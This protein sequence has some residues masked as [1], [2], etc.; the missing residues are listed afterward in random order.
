VLRLLESLGLAVIR[1]HETAI[2]LDG[3]DPEGVPCVSLL[4]VVRLGVY[5]AT[6]PRLLATG[7]MSELEHYSIAEWEYGTRINY[8]DRAL[9]GL[10]WSG[11]GSLPHS[12]LAV[13][14]S[15]MRKMLP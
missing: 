11:A 6:C 1:P 10:R 13:D 7:E 3:D 9:R 8:L 15:L 12:G 14:R 4:S 2:D 5:V